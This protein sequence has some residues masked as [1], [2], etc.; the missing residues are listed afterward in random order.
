MESTILQCASQQYINSVHVFYILTKIWTLVITKLFFSII[1]I[2]FLA[3]CRQQAIACGNKTA[4]QQNLPVFNWGFRLTK[5]DLYNGCN[6]VVVVVVIVVLIVIVLLLL[7][8]ARLQCLLSA[9]SLSMLW[10]MTLRVQ[11][12]ARRWYCV[13]CCRIWLSTQRSLC[14]HT[15]KQATPVNS[16]CLPDNSLKYQ[17]LMETS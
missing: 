9:V 7:L 16:C 12:L 5:I 14:Q 10:D 2:I 13:N 6:M 15:P 3:S 17:T 1:Y 4:L 11:M 8:L